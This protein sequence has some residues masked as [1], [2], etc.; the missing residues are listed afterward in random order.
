MRSKANVEM[1]NLNTGRLNFKTT[2]NSKFSKK[3]FLT[4]LNLFIILNFIVRTI[5]FN[6]F[7]LYFGERLLDYILIKYCAL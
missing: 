1:L 3:K 7:Y 4:I 5:F 6:K 2:T